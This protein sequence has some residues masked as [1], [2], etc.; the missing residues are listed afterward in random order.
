LALHE[1]SKD[2]QPPAQDY[3]EIRMSSYMQPIFFEENKIKEI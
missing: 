1:S 2:I 3:R